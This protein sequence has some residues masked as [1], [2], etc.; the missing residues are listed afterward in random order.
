MTTLPPKSVQRDNLGGIQKGQRTAPVVLTD[1]AAAE[2]FDC[3]I[4][5]N[6]ANMSGAMTHYCEEGVRRFP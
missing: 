4:I 6:F 5:P 1:E 2:F 3:R